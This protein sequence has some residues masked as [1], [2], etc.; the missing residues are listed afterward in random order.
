M[1]NSNIQPGGYCASYQGFFKICVTCDHFKVKVISKTMTV[2]N[3]VFISVLK[4]REGLTL[5][6]QPIL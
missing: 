5:V 3:V 4:Q 2:D 1:R 6:M